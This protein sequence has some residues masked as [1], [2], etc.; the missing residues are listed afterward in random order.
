M[1]VYTKGERGKVTLEDVFIAGA[2]YAMLSL[3]EQQSNNLRKESITR[4]V[5]SKTGSGWPF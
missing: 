3:I 2:E 4:E 1:E 5:C